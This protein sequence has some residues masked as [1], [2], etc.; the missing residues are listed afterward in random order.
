MHERD[1]R[2]EDLQNEL[3]KSQLE[4]AD[5]RE[6]LTRTQILLEATESVDKAALFEE[7][8]ENAKQKAIQI[9]KESLER[10]TELMEQIRMFNDKQRSQSEQIESLTYQNKKLESRLQKQTQKEK[11][12][13]DKTKKT[14]S[15]T[16]TCIEALEKELQARDTE[17]KNYISTHVLANEQ[18]TQENQQ[19]KTRVQLLELEIE[20]QRKKA[21]QVRNGIEFE[22][23]IEAANRKESIT[24]D[25]ETITLLELQIEKLTLSKQTL[26]T[27]NQSL[28][29][30]VSK[31]EKHI[32]AYFEEKPPKNDQIIIDQLESEKEELSQQCTILNDLVESLKGK[33]DVRQ[34]LVTV[35]RQLN[36]QLSQE[37]N[38]DRAMNSLQSQLSQV[39]EQ[40][41]RERSQRILLE[42][43]L[44]EMNHLEEIQREE[45]DAMKEQLKDDSIVEHSKLKQYQ[46]AYA[47]QSELVKALTNQLQIQQ[48]RALEQLHAE[49]QSHLD[50]VRQVKEEKLV[51]VYDNTYQELLGLIGTVLGKLDQSTNV[52]SVTAQEIKL[53]MIPMLR[54]AQ[55]YVIKFTREE[56]HRKRIEWENTIL[57]AK[58]DGLQETIDKLVN[59]KMISEHM[60]NSIETRLREQ[61]DK[62]DHNSKSQL[63]LVQHQVKLLS[64]QLLDTNKELLGIER[65][66]YQAESENTA[67]RLTIQSLE[68]EM[69]RALKQIEKRSLERVKIWQEELQAELDDEILK[70][71]DDEEKEIAELARE[72]VASRVV[73]NNLQHCLSIAKTKITMFK[74]MSVLTKPLNTH[75]KLPLYETS[76]KLEATQAQVLRLQ[77]QLEIERQIRNAPPVESPPIET[78]SRGTMTE[79]D[80]EKLKRKKQK[81]LETQQL[82]LQQKIQL[83]INQTLDKEIGAVTSQQLAQMEKL[84]KQFKQERTRYTNQITELEQK[85]DKIRTQQEKRI[86]QDLEQQR[87]LDKEE[88]LKSEKDRKELSSL[89]SEI[90]KLSNELSNSRT[91]GESL[92]REV[93]E[94]NKRVK[95]RENELRE[96]EHRRR[97]VMDESKTIQDQLKSVMENNQKQQSNKIQD[98]SKELEILK[99]LLRDREKE[100]QQ[101]NETSRTERNQTTDQLEELRKKMREREIEMEKI[102]ILHQESLSNIKQALEQE[103]SN[104]Q[105]L[106]T[107]LTQMRQ[108]NDTL[109]GKMEQIPILSTKI[110]KLEKENERYASNVKKIREQKHK[111]T[112]EF[113]QS[114]T[115]YE[116]QV[117]D[118]TNRIQVVEQ[119]KLALETELERVNTMMQQVTKDYTQV[120]TEYDQ[121]KIAQEQ[122]LSTKYITPMAQLQSKVQS[123]VEKVQTITQ[124]R[125]STA[126]KLDDH[127]RLLS[128][129]RETVTNLQKSIQEQQ[130]SFKEE[131]L[132]L[133]TKL[134]ES[135]QKCQQGN[136]EWD[137]LVQTA[138]TLK[139]A[140]KQSQDEVVRKTTLMNQMKSERDA[141]LEKIRV[142]EQE[143]AQLR[144]NDEKLKKAKSNSQRKDQLNTELRAKIASLETE[145]NSLKESSSTATTQYRNRL[146]NLKFEIQNQVH[147]QFQTQLKSNEELIER[148]KQEIVELKQ[149]IESKDTIIR[150]M[151]ITKND[152][153]RELNTARGDVTSLQ[154]SMI[155]KDV[156]LRKEK[157]IPATHTMIEGPKIEIDAEPDI[158]LTLLNLSRSE[159]EDFM[160]TLKPVN[161]I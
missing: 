116:Q 151:K 142:C 56:I 60:T 19:L 43:R 86:E 18:L 98:L 1:T 144:D 58:L 137:K 146:N 69:Q 99:S 128:E 79:A 37:M 5:L 44:K 121:Y 108:K 90:I 70:R 6:Q 23:F 59:D 145:L 81:A 76:S 7:E 156:M 28:K 30:Q 47:E 50:L 113:D 61:M 48:S 141:D 31:L 11:I 133:R 8:V 160:G 63:L 96:A 51:Q 123:L 152:L 24:R 85:L 131:K 135:I 89:Q 29:S 93:N 53:W 149:R 36:A 80:I 92:R 117:Q 157:K 139:R 77:N 140:L 14:S 91:Y 88:K 110:E 33:K 84:E 21:Q 103:Q 17:V 52:W 109:R 2:I 67:L 55:Q 95:D 138:G 147:G 119:A 78:V 111:I 158:S 65:S 150:K 100:I 127:K 105:R 107:A 15:E 12:L 32:F 115:E 132:A 134:S 25:K 104:S 42:A 41:E 38:L 22:S 10:E 136:E 126:T 64:N 129:A 124:E 120:S 27:E 97:I 16:N 26:D 112:I 83:E 130:K 45:I 101:I 161:I 143:L 87:R 3:G 102:G 34:Q 122:L 125:N 4:T 155:R 94:L 114:K 72:L 54:Q 20:E 40:Y 71:L 73:Q 39:R 35:T 159:Y 118:L 74:G 13:L 46:D 68:S 106:M 62:Q 66:L 82:A 49:K 75:D 9:R 148:L 154:Q 57:V 153:E